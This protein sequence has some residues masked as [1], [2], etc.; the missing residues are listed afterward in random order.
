MKR[1][2]TITMFHITKKKNVEEISELIEKI[3]LFCF[4]FY[5]PIENDR[6]V[7]LCI[8]NVVG[9]TNVHSYQTCDDEQHRQ[10]FT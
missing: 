4:F 3:F 7:G 9:S 10:K 2:I 8:G 1:K 5:F 6:P